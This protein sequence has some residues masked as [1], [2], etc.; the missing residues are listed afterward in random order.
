MKKA[1]VTTFTVPDS[2]DMSRRN[3]QLSISLKKKI[4]FLPN[5]Y[6]YMT[7]SE[8]ALNHYL[9][10]QNR[11]STLSKQE[12]EVIKVLVSQLNQCWYCLSAHTEFLKL[13][14]LT[15]EQVIEIRK[16]GASFD[17]RL[18]ALVQFTTAIINHR[19][20]LSEQAII[21]FFLAGYNEANLIDLV[22]TI[23]EVIIVNYLQNMVQVENDF[24]VAD[25]IF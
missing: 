20:D 25:N 21:N 22:I 1:T 18:E 7:K 8:T 13:T 24:P 17:A 3:R 19:G 5:L 10:L 12:R 2:S 6:A 15:E 4:G 9:Q 16:G 11:E 14:E 23:G